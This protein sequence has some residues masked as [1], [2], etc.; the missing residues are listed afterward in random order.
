M[1]NPATAD[2]KVRRFRGFVN[3]WRL[4]AAP[5]VAAAIFTS[6]IYLVGAVVDTS[7][8]YRSWKIL[9]TP[10]TWTTS[11]GN[12]VML[13]GPVGAGKTTVARELISILP[14]PVSYI[15]GDTFWSFIV[16][17]KSLDRRE[18]FRIILR[19]MTAAALPFARSG[20]DVLVDFS[21][22]PEFLKTARVIL[23][24]V[25]LDYILLRPSQAVCEARAAG[26]K[27]GAIV[28]YAPYR[29]FY[30]MFEYADRHII[31]DGEASAA[32][33][34]KRVKDGLSALA[35]RVS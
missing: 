17:S 26:R 34:A 5:L 22:P 25:P 11:V 20:Y 10:S 33:V 24:E 14:E 15:E 21:I 1:F 18:N 19:S 12:V 3:P 7:A 8:G 31:Q 9:W 16:K 23:K 6:F 32:D 28:D 13:S 2:A 30:S 27:Q 29:D 4:S 35:F